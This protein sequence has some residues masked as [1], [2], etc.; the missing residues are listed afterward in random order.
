MSFLDDVNESRHIPG[1][2]VRV[3]SSRRATVCQHPLRNAARRHLLP[4]AS[5]LQMEIV[6]QATARLTLLFLTVG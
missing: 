6:S 5:V 3:F 4:A 1:E 2:F